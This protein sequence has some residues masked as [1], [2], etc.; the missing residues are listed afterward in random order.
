MRRLLLLCIAVGLAVPT[1]SATAATKTPVAFTDT[2]VT[3][4]APA[5]SWT[6]DGVLHVRN[7]PQTLTLSGDLTGSI[8]LNVSLDLRLDTLTGAIYGQ[9]E[10]TT[11]TV[12]W[13]GSFAGRI[14]PNG[15]SGQFAGQG[16]D[17]TKIMGTFA[18]TGPGTFLDEAIILDPHE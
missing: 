10:I 6:G 14:T 11:D 5:R 9:F 17:D 18:Q 2:V 1:G 13:A 12:T 15:A 3:V 16:S 7:Q 4:G 8:S